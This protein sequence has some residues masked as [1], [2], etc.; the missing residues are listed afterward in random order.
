MKLTPP[1]EIA[2]LVAL[3]GSAP[4]AGAQPNDPKPEE[5]LTLEEYNVSG[6]R[7]RSYQT[8]RVQIG[9]FRDVNPVDVPLTINVVTR[10]ALDAQG[11]RSLY[12]ALRN[13]A[14]V[15]RAQSSGN[16]LDNIAIRGIRTENRSA[17]RLNGTLPV[18]NLVDMSL[19]NKER[20]EVLKGAA[21]LYY[22]FTE[23]SGII[24]LVTKRATPEP[25]TSLTVIANNH[26]A[27]T[28]HI[29]VSRRFARND[30]VG[31]R[32]N[33][34]QSRE[35]VG[36]D[37]Y[38]GKRYFA[39]IAADWKFSDRLLFRFDAEEVEKNVSEQ[40]TIFVNPAVGG[41]LTPPPLPPNTLNYAGEWQRFDAQMT[42][43]ILRADLLLSR[44]WVIV[45]EGGY[46]STQRSRLSSQVQNYNVTTGAAQLRI[47][48]N[49][50]MS[51]YNTNYRAELYGR[52]ATWKFN[53]N[54]TI[55]VTLN[56]REAPTYSNGNLTIA[57]NLYNPVPPPFT[58]SPT[59]TTTLT[60]NYIDEDAVYFYDRIMAFDD[61]I[62]V[63]GGMRWTDYSSQTYV[64]T[65]NNTTGATTTVPALYSVERKPIPMASIS[66][67]PTPKSSI[68]LSYLEGLEPGATAPLAQAN[69]GFV[70]PPLESTQYELGAKA[71]IGG[72]LV[73][74]A[75]FDIERPSTFINAQNV[76]T[77]NG[78]AT[79]QGYE[80]FVSGEIGR[81]LSIIASGIHLDAKQTNAENVST[82]NK[83]PENTAKYTG[84][85]FAEWRV[86]QIKGLSL[87]AGAFH[88]GRRAMDNQNRGFVGGYTT[89]SAG[90]SYRWQV[91][92]RDV[93][94]R[95]NADNLT[96]KNAWVGIGGSF[97][98]PHMPRSLKL[99]LNT[100]F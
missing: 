88:I 52:F 76:F 94:V 29:D 48:Y 33:Y 40:A 68:Y 96:D 12:D 54:L 41:V 69:A 73:Q 63:I 82:F 45:A 51:Y 19:E 15:T 35:D 24:N 13:T 38:A 89:Y 99:A 23:P 11:A 9:A 8:D 92:G 59:A 64:I 98:T 14:G 81:D 22:G 31:V 44:N 49:P 18:V 27:L 3:L 91:G 85:L 2:L 32:V 42:A 87:S 28:G 1:R 55:G 97:A 7:V 70:L 67:K 71:E 79:Y 56:D 25:L 21:S 78:T 74:L 62:Q 34:A 20:V 16:V 58:P 93:L 30:S 10:E 43:Y 36:I 26:G 86:P 77:A 100:K 50:S 39:S 6:S 95:F 65:R 4:F 60:D 17:F 47:T 84:S 75:Y 83:V 37:N 72:V 5:S 57:T 53:H 46:T 80:F 90:V 61:R 66:Y